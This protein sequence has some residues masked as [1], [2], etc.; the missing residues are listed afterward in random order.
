MST[1]NGELTVYND[2][3]LVKER[4]PQ[5]HPLDENLYALTEQERVL[6]RF[7][8]EKLYY[9][10]EQLATAER[11]KSVTAQLFAAFSQEPVLMD[12]RWIDRLPKYEPDRSR[13]IVDYIAGMTDR[14]AIAR[15]T[16]IFGISPV[17]LRNV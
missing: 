13:H 5:T 14:Y 8:Y 7:M 3:A 12:D 10:P 6:K 17:G 16:D 4:A 11:A 9:H 2:Q 15:H 1:T